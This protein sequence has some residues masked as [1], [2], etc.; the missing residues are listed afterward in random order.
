MGKTAVLEKALMSGHTGLS[1]I[2]QTKKYLVV[3]CKPFQEIGQHSMVWCQSF[4]GE[5]LLPVS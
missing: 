4:E 3:E 1:S 2:P 5:A